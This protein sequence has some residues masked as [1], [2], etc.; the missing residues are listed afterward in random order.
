MNKTTI[1]KNILEK[2]KR[3]F[4]NIH[5]TECMFGVGKGVHK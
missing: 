3:M 5:I 2:W 1:L 4:Y